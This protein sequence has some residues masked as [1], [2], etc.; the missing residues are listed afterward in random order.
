[1]ASEVT[2][3]MALNSY[4]GDANLAAGEGTGYA[5]I[6]LSPLQTY[7]LQKY[8][9][10]EL[11]F[12][13]QQEDRSKLEKLYTDPAIHQQL[14][15]S[16]GDQLNPIANK[17]KELSKKNLQ[18]NPNSKDWYDFMDT[19]NELVQTNAKLKAVQDI[20]NKAKEK[21]GAS[22]NLHE[23][24]GLTAYISQLDNYKLG[25]EV[26][27]YNKYFDYDPKHMA[28]LVTSQVT[29]QVP[30]A[31]GKGI[32]TVKTT[33]T[34]PLN[35]DQLFQRKLVENPYAS[36]TFKD[37]AHTT[38]ESGDYETINDKAAEAYSNGMILNNNEL[39][40]KY[41]AEYQKFKKANPAGTFRDFMVSS[42]KDAELAA[43]QKG[44]D[45]LKPTEKGVV[46]EVPAETDRELA[47]YTYFQR[48]N[49][50]KVR[51]NKPDYEVAAIFKATETVPGA[52]EEVL[53]EKL[54]V[55]PKD[56]FEAKKRLDLERMQQGGANYRAKMNDD[57]ERY[58]ANLKDYAD[59]KPDAKAPELPFTPL[60]SIVAA[61]GENNKRVNIT[62][63]PISQIAAI[64]PNW[65]DAKGALKTPKEI[66]DIEVSVGKRSDGSDGVFVVKK[67]LGGEVSKETINESKLK[68]NAESW[69]ATS[70]KER[71][72]QEVY[73]Y[74]D[75]LYNAAK[76]KNAITENKAVTAEIPTLKTKAE[77]DALPKGAF[78]Y[79]DGKKYQK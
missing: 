4:R 3:R 54:S 77:F 74:I 17:L 11:D 52:K 42:G 22:P 29:K 76:G 2:S 43:V 19:H 47:G 67:T 50:T 33:V 48:P 1:M 28:S 66:G 7:A 26:P 79:R 32:R 60:P 78:Y 10:N 25:E 24:E 14:D 63:L 34:N 13:Q 59:G 39:Q 6:D 71:K 58:K 5:K 30:T 51:L 75:E 55:T 20:K 21:L 27:V 46:F 72:G 38:L 73:G 18:M 61:I 8:R 56:E 65:L 57:T 45:F 53:E 15:K 62:S 36:Q 40:T 31:D 70:A 37:I 69:L 35:A 64:N 16:Y 44:H 23:K 68:S 12:N 49:G 41:Q 9:T